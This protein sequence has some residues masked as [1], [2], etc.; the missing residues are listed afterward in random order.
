MAFSLKWSRACTDALSN[1]N[2]AIKFSKN[3]E[4]HKEHVHHLH[5]SS[6][7]RE[8]GV[9]VHTSLPLTR[10]M[11]AKIAVELYYIFRSGCCQLTGSRPCL[12]IL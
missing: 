5:Y 7:T 3:C 9:F 2:D 4:K 12:Y 6:G 1:E 8:T 11:N 10:N